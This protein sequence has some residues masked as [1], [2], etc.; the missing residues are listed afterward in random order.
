[1]E[2]FVIIALIIIV[3]FLFSI[4]TNFNDPLE[5]LVF[6]IFNKKI[7]KDYKYYIDE[8]SINLIT[9]YL[10]YF[11]KLH[12]DK[13]LDYVNSKIYHDIL[14]NEV[15]DL[16]DEINVDIQNVFVDG[17]E[18]VVVKKWYGYN[19]D[20][21]IIVGFFDELLKSIAKSEIIIDEVDYE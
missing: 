1:M 11:K 6:K 15:C 12:S 18:H 19:F 7:L 4:D 3:V 2:L 5:D 20:Y 17:L 14:F 16:L 21:E 13:G 10:I 8:K 9:L